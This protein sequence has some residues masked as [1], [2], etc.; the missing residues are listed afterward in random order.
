[1]CCLVFADPGR[2]CQSCQVLVREGE[3]PNCRLS[4][5]NGMHD[6]LMS[7]LHAVCDQT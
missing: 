5:R 3:F 1:M 2:E 7:W 4:N 6:K